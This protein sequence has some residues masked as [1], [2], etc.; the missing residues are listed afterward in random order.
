LQFSTIIPIFLAWR[1]IGC[2]E[3]QSFFFTISSFSIL[4]SFAIWQAFF[5]PW[6]LTAPPLVAFFFIHLPFAFIIMTFQIIVFFFVQFIF[7]DF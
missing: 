3:L 6:L 7:F 2:S 1:L 4:P 5:L